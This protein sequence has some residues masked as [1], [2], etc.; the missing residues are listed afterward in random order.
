MN[1][2]KLFIPLALLLLASCQEWD[3]VFTLE[4]RE[5]ENYEPVHM[6]PTHTIAQIAK[7]YT[8]GN[9]YM[10]NDEVI[11]AGKVSSSDE[12][13]NFY[14]SIYIQDETG[15]IELKLGKSSLYSDYKPGQTVYVNLLGMKVGMYGYKELKNYS[16]GP[17]GGSGMVQIGLDD[18]TQEYETSYI[19][20]D[21]FI[22]QRVFRGERGDQVTP[23][24]LTEAQ[25]PSRTATL[26]TCPYLGKLVT[27]KGLKY[28]DEIFTLVYL[29]S[30]VDTDLS[31][32]R[33]FL[34][35]KTWG[36]TTWAMSRNKFVQN[37]DAGLFDSAM[38]GNSGDYNHGTVADHREQLRSNASAAT[39]SQYFTCGK[40][41]VVVRTSGYARFADSEIPAAVLDKSRTVD[42]TGVL[43]L[44]QGTIQLVINSLDDVKVN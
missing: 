36:V 29:D 22:R 34:S 24:E 35:D 13:G 30:N 42:I 27:V 40:T 43:T 21:A 33:V 12:Q 11:I 37:L 6:T 8:P 2:S 17:S 41:E 4:N 15:G 32:N 19:E 20:E 39:V 9:P 14:K 7:D 28:A 5:P 25:L 1:T 31:S 10:V 23:V 18:P 44:Y 16:D 26:A 38:I 3:P